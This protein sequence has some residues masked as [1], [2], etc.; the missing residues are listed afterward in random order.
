MWW[1]TWAI[2]LALE[3]FIKIIVIETVWQ[4][5]LDVSAKKANYWIVHLTYWS[6]INIYIFI[7]KYPNICIY[8]FVP[9]YQQNICVLF[10]M[11]KSPNK[12]VNYC[13]K[14]YNGQFFLYI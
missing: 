6:G 12:Y 3:I 13:D 8:N 7:Y 4:K 14:N 11:K 1:N 5:V 2:V 10:A 9:N